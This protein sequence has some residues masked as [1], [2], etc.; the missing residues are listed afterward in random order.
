MTDDFLSVRREEMEER[1]N[2]YNR[3][4]SVYNLKDFDK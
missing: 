4:K 3:K 2:Y 1:E